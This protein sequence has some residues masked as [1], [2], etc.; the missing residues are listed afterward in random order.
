[1]ALAV[2]PRYTEQHG[3]TG[4]GSTHNLSPTQTRCFALTS[5]KTIRT[6]SVL[7]P[8]AYVEGFLL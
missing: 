2:P 8:P 6:A 7:N 5:L 4:C 1:M 3:G